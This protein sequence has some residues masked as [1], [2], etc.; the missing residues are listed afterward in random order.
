M[1]IQSIASSLPLVPHAVPPASKVQWLLFPTS[2]SAIGGRPLKERAFT[3]H[4]Y[5]E[6]VRRL[7]DKE[8][9]T[10][11]AK[12]DTLVG[13][14]DKI[15]QLCSAVV[16]G[17]W[18]DPIFKS[19]DYPYYALE[20][21]QQGWIDDSQFSTIQLFWSIGQYHNGYDQVQVYSLFLDNESPNP[22]ALV[23]IRQSFRPKDTIDSLTDTQ[24]RAFL[25]E[26]KK[27]PLSEQYFFVVPDLQ[28]VSKR[29]TISQRIHSSPFNV[30]NRLEGDL[31]MIP[32]FGMM[33]EILKTK[34]GKE[35]VRINPVLGLST[36]D[37][38]RDASKRDMALCFPGV[39]LPEEADHFLA[40]FYDFTYHDFF[41]SMICSSMP[42]KYRQMMITVAGIAHNI[43][44][45]KAKYPDFE[46]VADTIN[47]VYATALD[48]EVLIFPVEHPKI[49]ALPPEVRFWCE[50][51]ALA[52]KAF[53]N[54]DY[55]KYNAA[56][57]VYF[58]ERVAQKLIIEGEGA[59]CRLDLDSLEKASGVPFNFDF[60]T[61]GTINEIYPLQIMLNYI[62]QRKRGVVIQT[63]SE[64]GLANKIKFEK[65]EHCTGRELAT[66]EGNS[67]QRVLTP[68]QMHSLSPGL[69]A[70][71]EEA[72]VHVFRLNRAGIPSDAFIA[73]PPSTREEIL[74]KS[75]EVVEL[76]LA[77]V[78][79]E[80][81][82]ALSPEKF[83]EVLIESDLIL[84]LLTA[85]MS[86]R[87][88]VDCVYFAELLKNKN[89]TKAFLTLGASLEEIY[90]L[91]QSGK[92][93][94]WKELKQLAEAGI[95]Y[96]ILIALEDSVLKALM[97]DW[98]L[99]IE[100]VKTG[101]ELEK[102]LKINQSKLKII[103]KDGCSIRLL[104]KARMPFSHL[105]SVED[106]RYQLL[107]NK[108]FEIL[109]FVEKLGVSITTLMELDTPDLVN[110]CSTH[111]GCRWLIEKKFPLK[112]IIDTLRA[113]KDM[114]ADE[115]P[116]NYFFFLSTLVD[117]GTSP[118]AFTSRLL[119]QLAW[120]K[121]VDETNSKGIDC[122]IARINQI[123]L[124]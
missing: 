25:D 15:G 2:A 35:A 32:S 74:K 95:S 76:L 45:E 72:H 108:S 46:G 123:T 102:L 114:P 82:N 26:M 87:Q 36:L 53:L 57:L 77:G 97:D 115:R 86:W 69:K 17:D 80:E 120:V 104:L 100:I 48:M 79:W 33:Q 107:V 89:A 117:K 5:Q 16:R 50:V 122:L 8:R 54:F 124:D 58:Y 7:S 10:L 21:F 56:V 70:E 81:L 12:M 13:Q 63:S 101:M 24:L 110:L 71:L 9:T 68:E 113:E 31:R 42:F 93:S 119:D 112:W 66:L 83:T 3:H 41:H 4:R 44:N 67:L 84:A 121:E 94:F 55:E 111:V 116:S 19:V 62:W 6:M 78:S 14:Q 91:Y 90:T 92:I 39:L 61:T 106:A 60:R 73:L 1:I 65:F 43:W 75:S 118:E 29:E 109:D 28:K 37:D 59:D 64:P 98:L 34:Y 22:E 103:F 88:I 49:A 40:P 52:K 11:H 99:I 47:S 51:K 96:K 38:F 18:N 20:A 27:L 105:L 85:G 23:L 30:F